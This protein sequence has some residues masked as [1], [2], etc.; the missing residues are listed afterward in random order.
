MLHGDSPPKKTHHGYI[1]LHTSQYIERNQFTDQAFS[2]WKTTLQT[3]YNVLIPYDQ[4]R[5]E[6]M[7]DL[8]K[9]VLNDICIYGF[10]ER[11]KFDNPKIWGKK[12]QIKSCALYRWMFN[13][14]CRSGLWEITLY[15]TGFPTISEEYLLKNEKKQS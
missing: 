11:D 4:V 13:A 15:T 1:V 7:T 3:P 10:V 14:N 6:I 9:H 8:E 2:A 12:D 5:N